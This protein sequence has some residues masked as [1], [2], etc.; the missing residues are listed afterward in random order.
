[1]KTFSKLCKLLCF[2]FI[3][4]PFFTSC[5]NKSNEEIPYDAY[6]YGPALVT[7]YNG[8]IMLKSTANQLFYSSQLTTDISFELTDGTPVEVLIYF[9]AED[10]VSED[11]L[12]GRIDYLGEYSECL[13]SEREDLEDDFNA[14][15][16]FEY[17][18]SNDFQRID[19]K[20]FIYFYT[21]YR[22]GQKNDCELVYT[23]VSSDENKFIFHLKTKV[24]TEGSGESRARVLGV[25]VD[26]NDFIAKEGR[27]KGRNELRYDFK[28]MAGVDGEDNVVYET[29]FTNKVLWK[30]DN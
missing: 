15:I 21:N 9:Y 24:T 10:Q 11:Y 18:G 29:L 13:P 8:K 7:S 20:W 22:E 1:M 14:A 3:L 23:P 26:L 28:Y 12:V 4:S 5:L 6:Y 17:T 19:N 25:A 27:G 16:M 30:S 2:S